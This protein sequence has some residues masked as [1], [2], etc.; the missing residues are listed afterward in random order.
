MDF[1]WNCVLLL[2]SEL[3]GLAV[4]I[5]SLGTNARYKYVLDTIY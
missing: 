3:M 5:G 1:V 2:G 4:L